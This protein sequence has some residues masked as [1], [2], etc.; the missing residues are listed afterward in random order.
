MRLPTALL[1]RIVAHARRDFPNEC[2]GMVGVR[3]GSAV[4]VHEATNVAASPLRFEVDGL[5]VLRADDAFAAEGAEMGAI[6]HSHTRTE[7]YPSQTDINFAAGWP[8]LEW[9]IV[10]LRADGEPTVRSYR[11]DGGDVTEVEVEVDGR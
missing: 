9:L 5:E 10:G 2:C 7:P 8:G 4:A 1:E 3:D 11:I 6:Y